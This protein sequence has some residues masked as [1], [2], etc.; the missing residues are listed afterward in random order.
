MVGSV[1]EGQPTT[2][3]N[4]VKHVDLSNR[5]PEFDARR[6]EKRWSHAS[7]SCLRIRC[8]P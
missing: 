5:E 7:R 3:S 4:P 1:V 6:N 8:N 2:T